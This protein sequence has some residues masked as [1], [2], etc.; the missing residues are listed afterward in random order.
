MEELEK[1][2]KKMKRNKTPG[3]D[4]ITMEVFKDMDE[5]NREY[6]L[7]IINEWWDK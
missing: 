1:N 5:G 4:E 3:P 7:E 2:L 6:V